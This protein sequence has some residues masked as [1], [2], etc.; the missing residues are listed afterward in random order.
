MY[1]IVWNIKREEVPTIGKLGSVNEIQ[2]K[3]I[4]SRIKKNPNVD[5]TDINTIKQVCWIWEG[6]IQDK[7][8]KGH[9]HGSLFFN[10][11]QVMIH[12]LMYHNFIEDVPVY[13]RCKDSLQVNHTCKSDGRCV[14]PYH[15][16]LGTPKENIRD[17]ILDGNKNKF[18]S[19]ENNPN[20]IIS[21]ETV[22]HIKSLKNKT[23]KTQKELAKIYGVN[24]SQISRWWNNKTR[25]DEK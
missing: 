5:K 9:Q 18:Y 3:R 19:G 8:R 17:C 10:G 25:N 13:K 12:R 7:S 24:Q 15:M 22:K 20:S 6:F 21:D 2:K 1:D 23:T 14:N 4:I 16:Y 11:K